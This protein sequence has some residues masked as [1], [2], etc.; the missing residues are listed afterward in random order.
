MRNY[1]LAATAL[2]AAL[3]FGMTTTAQATVI[4]GTPNVNVATSPYTISFGDSDQAT[5]TISGAGDVG[6]GGNPVAVSTG[7]TALVASLGPPFYD[8]AQ[9]T[10]YFEGSSI[11]PD[12]F[13]NFTAFPSP[14]PVNFSSTDTFLGLKFFLDDGVHYGYAEVYG[15]G[16]NDG[17]LVYSPTL[18]S[19][20]YESEPGVAILTGAAPTGV[21]VPEPSG[22]AIFGLGL[23]I[24]G[25]GLARR[26]RM[27]KVDA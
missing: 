15:Y 23:G 8:P 19:F 20:G 2:S 18:V 6:F 22:L 7:G 16:V 17:G 24:A 14:T 12:T 10:S 9:P 4:G 11:G 27:G 21:A 26:R 13:V 25:L 5:Y 3:G 1:I